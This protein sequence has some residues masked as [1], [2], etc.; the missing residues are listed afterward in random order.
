VAPAF[1]SRSLRVYGF[2]PVIF[3][4]LVPPALL[5]RCDGETWSEGMVAAGAIGGWMILWFALALALL[6]GRKKTPPLASPPP[7]PNPGADALT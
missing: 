5:G 6:R 7:G 4:L 3:F 2:G 1:I